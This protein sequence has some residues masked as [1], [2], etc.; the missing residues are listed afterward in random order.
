M[1]SVGVSAAPAPKQRIREAHFDDYEKIAA[2]Q[3]R[4]GLVPRPRARWQALWER[5]PAHRA[6]SAIGW[7]IETGPGEIGGYIGNLPLLYRF[8][9]EEIRAAT[10]YSWATD[11]ACRGYSLALLDRVVRQ[12][13]VDLI[14]CTTPN[15][16]ASRVYT[17]VQFRKIPAG[18]WEKSHFWITG[19]RGFAKSAL[20][21][22][23]IPGLLASPAAG[24]LYV[25]DA[26]RGL[27]RARLDPQFEILTRFDSRFDRFYADLARE[28]RDRLFAVRDRATLEW[29]FGESLASGHAWVLG[30]SHG[31][32]LVACA[33]LD[34]RDHSALDLK[35]IRFADFQ[36]LEG[37]KHGFEPALSAALEICRAQGAHVLENTGC[38]LSRWGARPPYRRAMKTW[39][40]YYKT[41]RAA[42]ANELENPDVWVPTAFDGD[43]SL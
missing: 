38:W 22:Q 3:L 12:P 32:R 7:V 34:R 18:D 5:N 9:G 2:L 8:K 15:A 23:N 42:L 10:P 41:L 43:A 30:A 13:G 6:N 11:P 20:R 28:H 19:Y 37:W 27:G 17:A 1:H 35:R 40:F 4:N 33:I 26:L 25:R 29:H 14:V 31:G 39:G 36:A 24:A 16:P 21:S